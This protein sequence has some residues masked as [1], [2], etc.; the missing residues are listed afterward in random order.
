MLIAVIVV[1]DRRC[2]PAATTRRTSRRP[3][4][5]TPR[6]TAHAAVGRTRR[7][8]PPRRRRRTRRPPDAAGHASTGVTVKGATDLTGDPAVTSKATTAAPKLEVQGPRRRQGQGGHADVDV[9]VQYTGV[10]YKNGTVV[11]LVLARGGPG[12]VPARPASVARLHPGHRRHDRQVAADEGRRP[13]DH[14]PPGRAG[15]RRTRPAAAIPANSPLVFVVDLTRRLTRFR[16]RPASTA[17]RGRHGAGSQ[18]QTRAAAS[19][20]AVSAGGATAR[21]RLDRRHRSL[22]I[23]RRRASSSSVVGDDRE[24]HQTG[25]SQPPA[26]DQDRDDTARRR[27]PRRRP[28]RRRRSPTLPVQLG[29]Q[30]TAP[31]AKQGRP[32]RR[33]PSRRR[34]ARSPSPCTTTRGPDDLHP[35]PGRRAVHGRELRLAGQAEVLRRHRRATG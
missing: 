17:P 22:V 20:G 34:P 12:H 33:R 24:A 32:C 2:S 28:H 26:C 3:D 4:G 25:A 7:R 8:Q 15:L 18:R 5:S 19:S 1:V 23:A 10:L 31:P 16:C 6:S 29:Q 21:D 13:A 11:R 35:R 9:T 30:R 27:R 14:H